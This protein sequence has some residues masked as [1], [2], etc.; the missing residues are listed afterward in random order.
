MNA[1]ASP[2]VRK[3]EIQEI[4]EMIPHRYPFLLI[5]QVDIMSDIEAVG[6]KSVTINEPFFQGHF[7]KNPVMPGVLIVESMAQTS[8]VL[9]VEITKENPGNI[10]YFMTIDRARFRKPVVPGDQI[11]LFIKKLKNR[12]NV[13]KFE[14]N[15]FVE[16]NLIAEAKFSAMIME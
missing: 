9:V 7:P 1:K 5:D 10:V 2:R 11:S 13:W 14:G 3:I 12:G 16:G 6:K 4:M 8:A 15:A